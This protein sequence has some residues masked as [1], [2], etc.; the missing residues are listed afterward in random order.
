MFKDLS[1]EG[2]RKGRKEHGFREK[3]FHFHL[4]VVTLGK[5]HNHRV[6]NFPICKTG[7]KSEHLSGGLNTHRDM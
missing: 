7:N 6:L 1:F 4:L 2:G 3:A 5:L